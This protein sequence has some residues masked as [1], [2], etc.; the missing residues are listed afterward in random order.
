[1]SK[2]KEILDSFEDFELAFLFRYRLDTYM[3]DTKQIIIEY[4]RNKGLSDDKINNLISKQLNLPP[5][6]TGE[7]RCSRCK[8]NKFVIDKVPTDN[9]ATLYYVPLLEGGKLK[10]L[11]SCEV[12]G[13]IFIDSN[14]EVV[15]LKGEGLFSFFNILFNKFR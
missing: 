12:C 4:I 13:L 3:Q 6:K 8:S 1:M 5:V 14:A 9:D 11:I 7:K 2:I 15:N 10:E